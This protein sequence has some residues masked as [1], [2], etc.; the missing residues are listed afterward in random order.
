MRD[1][2]CRAAVAPRPRTASRRGAPL[3][4]TALLLGVAGVAAGGTHRASATAGKR[5]GAPAHRAATADVT[6]A[7][8]A[9]EPAAALP[10]LCAPD[11]GTLTLALVDTSSGLPSPARVEILDESGQTWIAPGS[12]AVGGGDCGGHVAALPG[13][14]AAAANPMLD[15]TDY[16][17]NPHSGA[18]QFYLAAEST[19][20]L[21]PGRYRVTAYKGFEYQPVV[22]QITIAPGSASRAVLPLARWI[23]MAAL[24]WFSADDHLHITRS[25]PDDDPRLAR[26]MQA[27]DVNVAN[28]LQMDF[29]P[30]VLAATQYAF[31][32]RHIFQDGDTIIASGQENPRT[33][34][35]GHG[36]I[37]GAASY[38]DF[39]D[40]PLEYGRYWQAAARDGAL[41]GY[42]HWGSGAARD[43][44]AIDAQ[45][46]NIDFLEVLQSDLASY[47]ALYDILGLGIRMTPTAGT[48][49]PCALTNLPGRDR[50]YTRVDGPLTY[51]SWMTAIRRGRTFV[52][53]G[54]LLTEFSVGDARVGD[55]LRLPAPA[56]LAVR[57]TVR[58][59]PARDD[60]TALELVLDGEVVQVAQQRSAPGEIR[61]QTSLEVASSA[62][63]ALRAVGRKLDLPPFA[64]PRTASAHTGPVY[65]AVGGAKIADRDT[66]RRLA[67][68]ELRRLARL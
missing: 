20:A 54:P 27:E 21:P 67:E 38:I 43:G 24:G 18:F 2:R 55:E 58:F 45:T 56:A 23:D 66:A 11:S 1:E 16:V 3:L 44:L 30:G 42:A 48:D 10:E 13:A 12:L 46:G 33:W 17:R 6:A 36:I 61:M 26:W 34:I 5:A 49:Y 65:V 40:S 52:S 32:P 64:R 59:D 35:L 57:G 7:L 39:P 8:C 51:A 47:D 63:I 4:A 22:R 37:L 29:V 50:F 31:G 53:N 60:V 68:E 19:L 41:R 9:R 28:L 62:W 14:G 15:V 25:G